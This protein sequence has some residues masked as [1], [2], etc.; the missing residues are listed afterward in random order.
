[1]LG[2]VTSERRQ[3]DKIDDLSEIE[4]AKWD[5]AVTTL[6]NPRHILVIKCE[7]FAIHANLILEVLI[8]ELA[9]ALRVLSKVLSSMDDLLADLLEHVL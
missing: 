3:G 4:F 6:S 2:D 5:L 9:P 8:D 7:F 1:M